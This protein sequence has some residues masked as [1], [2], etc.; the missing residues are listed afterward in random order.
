MHSLL[1]GFYCAL[2]V[3]LCIVALIDGASFTKALKL[4]KEDAT[5][6][7]IFLALSDE[8]KRDWVLNIA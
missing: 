3:H 1:D 2:F 7:E 4:L 6:R 5:W 8:P